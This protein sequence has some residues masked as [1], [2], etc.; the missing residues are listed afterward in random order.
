V[1]LFTNLHHVGDVMVQILTD[2][3][4]QPPNGQIQ[5]GPPLDTG[6]GAE[7]DIR[8]TLMWVTPQPTHRNDPPESDGA[9]G[10]VQP[11]ITVTATYLITTYG[12]SQ[13]DPVRAHELLGNVMQSFHT[14]PAVNLPLADLPGVGEGRLTFT[15]VPTTLEIMERTFLPLQVKH[16]SF[17]LFDVAPVQLPKFAPVGQPGA[18]VRPG[19]VNLGAV[20]P[21]SQ[22]IITRLTPAQQGPG[23]VVRLDVDL[24]GRTLTEVSL[25]TAAV[26]AASLTIVTPGKTFLMTL[27]PAVAANTL[28]TIRLRVGDR[29]TDPPEQFSPPAQLGVVATTGQTLDAPPA[30]TLGNALT[31]TGRTL[32][33]A[34][35]GVASEVLIWPDG[36]IAEPAEVR[37]LPPLAVTPTSVQ[38]SA[39]T[40]NGAALKA[41]LYR[42]AV[43][44]PNGSITPF[45][46][47]E[48]RS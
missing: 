36:A 16:R 47:L 44:F 18:L 14:V 38:L 37:S 33:S 9:G 12:S 2:N 42:A 20:S 7:E 35:S 17:V 8:I 13:D 32:S 5:V 4:P 29:V 6:N 25:G 22:P 3:V 45:V 31:L 40:M 39:S 1:A 23:G 19:G 46:I 34:T 10:V 24:Q 48:V 26:P 28:A 43:R 41:G 27:P 30:Y 15:Q 21:L 11:P